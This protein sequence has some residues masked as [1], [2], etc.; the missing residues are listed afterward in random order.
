MNR[1]HWS[2]SIGRDQDQDRRDRPDWLEEQRRVDEER[3]ARARHERDLA[4]LDEDRDLEEWRSLESRESRAA[5]GAGLYEG[6]VE[7]DWEGDVRWDDEGRSGRRYASESSSRRQGERS[8]PTFGGRDPYRR[9]GASEYEPHHR[10]GYYLA[11]NRGQERPVRR[12]RRSHRTHFSGV[13][14]YGSNLGFSGG[15]ASLGFGEDV[16]EAPGIS[17]IQGALRYEGIRGTTAEVGRGQHA[18]KGPKDFRRSDE[19]VREQICE[20]LMA[21]P[22]IDASEITLDVKDGEVTLEG[23]VP[24]RHTRRD[25]EE[26]AENVMGVSQVNNRLRIDGSS[27]RSA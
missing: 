11:L 21:D 2:P 16:G 14:D 1:Q 10:P 19:R 27:W 5:F 3:Y 6:R 17:A 26:C 12:R 25:A 15:T 9:P 18:G 20:R 8:S 24:D 4:D 23:N 22:D 7:R 13:A